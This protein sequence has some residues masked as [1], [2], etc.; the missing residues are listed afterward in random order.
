MNHDAVLYIFI[1]LRT[2]I[3][4]S[5]LLLRFVL[6]LPSSLADAVLEPVES[7]AGCAF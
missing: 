7:I 1:S 6:W 4:S 2:P 5:I 3:K